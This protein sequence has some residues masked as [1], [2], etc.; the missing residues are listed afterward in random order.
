MLRTARQLTVPNKTKSDLICVCILVAL[1]A[2]AFSPW[3]VGGKFFGPIDI[4]YELYE[5]WAA[6]DTVV[7]VHNHFTSDAVT[8]YLPYRAFAQ[9]AY[10]AEGRVAWNDLQ[11]MGVPAWA[12]TMAG[13]DDWTMQLHRWLDFSTAWHIGLALSALIAVIGMYFLLRSL[14]YSPG[15]ALACAVAFGLNSQFVNW[16][17]HRFQ[18]ASFGWVPWMVWAMVRS[19]AGDRHA[20]LLVPVFMALGFVGGTLQTA[21]YV[22]IVAGVVGLLLQS[23]Y[24]NGLQANYV[25]ATRNVLFRELLPWIAAAFGLAAYSGLGE[26]SMYLETIRS[27]Q[28]RGH[29]GYAG[30]LR[31]PVSSAIFAF[32]QFAPTL[33]GSARSLDLA[34]VLGGDLFNIAYAG[35][36]P[37]L[38]AMVSLFRSDAPREARV[39][40]C[41]GLVIPLTPLVGP[42]YHRVQIIW[43]FAAIWLFAWY[44]ESGIN[45]GGA[46]F[47]RRLSWVWGAVLLG[48][49]LL[50]AATVIFETEIS[51][52]IRDEVTNRLAQGEGQFGA[53][54]AWMETRTDR[55][56]PDLRIWA[57]RQLLWIAGFTLCLWALVRRSGGRAHHLPLLLAGLILELGSYAHSWITVVDPIEYPVYAA[58]DDLDRLRK[59]TGEGFVHVFR[60]PD[61]EFLLP[62]NLLSVYGIRTLEQYESIRPIGAW[63]RSGF[64]TDSRAL[65]RLGV[66]IGVTERHAGWP[67]SGWVHERS[68]IRFEVWRNVH[69]VP[70]YLKREVVSGDAVPMGGA[71]VFADRAVRVIRETPS[72]RVLEIPADVS[73]VRVA[74]N[75]LPGWKSEFESHEPSETICRADGTIEVR[76]PVS[77]DD[78]RLRLV[79]E[80]PLRRLGTII[81]LVTLLFLFGVTAIRYQSSQFRRQSAGRASG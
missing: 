37:C 51:H 5:P 17:Y 73:G 45:R 27:G 14:Q 47:A 75:C 42:L 68:E 44:W 58:R 28:V 16:I 31:D 63:Q 66:T 43:V 26:V 24:G 54:S 3:W 32:V 48:W 12:N 39:L 36:L 4:V 6:G 29:I 80:P 34:K 18:L 15:I 56:I 61:S 59:S 71:T 10:A 81:S 70:R 35:T 46:A 20:Y 13:Y 1:V 78:R 52:L 9:A 69:A 2:L 60:S 33:L 30:G 38:V 53:Y 76:F 49:V 62:P 23:G 19:R 67:G 55:L 79:Y 77:N 25:P 41:L 72:E 74:E 65:G 11:Y 22:L 57:P 21:I 40:A 64:L 50:S 8:Q 7:S